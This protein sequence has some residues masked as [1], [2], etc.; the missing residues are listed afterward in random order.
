MSS[1]LKALRRVE[2]ERPAQPQRRSMRGDIVGGPGPKPS[3]PPRRKK[4]RGPNLRLWGGLGAALLLAALVWWR[5]PS[6][7]PEGEVVEAQAPS[8][9][10][11]AAPVERAA[12][13]PA[14]PP[15]PAASPAPEA[16]PVAVAPEPSPAADGGVPAELA[17]QLPPLGETLDTTAL[18]P[19]PEPPAVEALPVEP[20]AT[21]APTPTPKPAPP[22][23][24]ARAAP[25]PT[26]VAKPPA[27][28]PA[29]KP[30]P[31]VAKRPP[32]PP[33]SAPTVLVERASWHPKPERRVAWIRLEG[34]GT[35]RELHEGDAVGTL[36]VKEIRPS[37]VVF[38][39]G[40]EEL[41]RRVGDH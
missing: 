31:A 26:P 5:L 2:A 19:L 21:V 11:A 28:A 4:S 10:E 12:E 16:P 40:A 6:P 17:Q 20:A 9:A 27:P 8:A 29:A 41:T 24:A 35:T 13:P 23:R 1:I 15:A 36:V 7:A 39:H 3:P 32:A 34:S 22:R 33:P 18:A 38:V 37:S 30:P 14:P 25:S